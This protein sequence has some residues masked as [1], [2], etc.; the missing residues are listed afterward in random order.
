[1]SRDEE[2][3]IEYAISAWLYRKR[4]S[5]GFGLK[6]VAATIGVSTVT[7]HLWEMGIR[8]P[9]TYARRKAW[10]KALNCRLEI[11]LVNTDGKRESF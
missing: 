9:G 3:F 4:R 6:D 5:L 2:R 1:M 8:S 11:T 7:V 10:A